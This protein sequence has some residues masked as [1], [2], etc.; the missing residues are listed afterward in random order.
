MPES[1][2]RLVC[3]IPF[4][5]AAPLTTVDV[6]TADGS[7]IEIEQRD[8]EELTHFRGQRVAAEG[9]GVRAIFEATLSGGVC[10]F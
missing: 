9:I 6:A 1:R 10:R 3:R 8:P 5:V 2:W 7:A 4:F